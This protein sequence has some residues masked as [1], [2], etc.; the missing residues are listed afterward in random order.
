KSTPQLFRQ[1]FSELGHPILLNEWEHSG[2]HRRKGRRKTKHCSSLF[3]T[4]HLLFAIRVDEE[5]E[6]GSVGADGGL[7]DVWHITAVI[8]LIEVLELLSRVLLMLCEIEIAAVVHAFD[9]LEAEAAAEVELDV[10]RGARIV[11]ELFL[12]VLM[13]LQPLLGKPEAAVP[14]HALLF[15]IFEPLLVR[16][17]LDEKLHLHLL[18]FASSKDEVSWRDLVAERLADLGDAERHLLTHRLLHVEK[19]HIDALRRLW[20]QEDLGRR[21]FYWPH[22]SSEHE[23]KQPRLG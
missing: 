7:D 2:L 14:L 8:R 3:L 23:V 6:R 12:L 4:R 5:S 10:E 21:V 20:P 16:A 11:C 22:E 18:E 13:E 15:P 17:W 19:V 1:L 9:L